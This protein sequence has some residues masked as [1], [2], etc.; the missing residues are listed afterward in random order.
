MYMMPDEDRR[1][2][3]MGMQ[4]DDQSRRKAGKREYQCDMCLKLFSCS[5]NLKRHMSVHTGYKPYTCQY[6]NMAFSNSSN[7]RKHERSH[8]RKQ[9]TD[10]VDDIDSPEYIESDQG[11]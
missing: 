3:A 7:R 5:S 2:A 11:F 4:F 9:Q 6:C 1:I 10:G 8:L